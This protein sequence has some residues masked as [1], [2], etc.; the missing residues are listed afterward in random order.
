MSD[1]VSVHLLLGGCLQSIEEAEQLIEALVD[2]GLID[3]TDEGMALLKDAISEHEKV[4]LEAL[5][6][7]YG[8][9]DVEG[10]LKEGGLTHLSCY[11]SFGRGYE[12]DA[13]TR[14]IHEGK[15]HEFLDADV[16][17]R[18]EVIKAL[19]EGGP[20]AVRDLIK[21]THFLQH[22]CVPPLTGSDE[23]RGWLSIL[24]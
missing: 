3:N 20:D 4:E 12:F 9:L 18:S 1:R 6:V 17:L 7:N 24:G 23:V 10:L 13:G 19:D 22:E 16:V 5:E 15:E 11:V 8:R 2:E 21:R 14:T